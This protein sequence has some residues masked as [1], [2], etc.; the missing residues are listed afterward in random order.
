MAQQTW[1]Q[2][3][4]SHDLQFHTLTTRPWGT[5]CFPTNT[6]Y[7]YVVFYVLFWGVLESTEFMAYHLEKNVCSSQ[8]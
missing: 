1:V 5:Q 3:Q 2:T 4:Q 8:G 6:M 7:F